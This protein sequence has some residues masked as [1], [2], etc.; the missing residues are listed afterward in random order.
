MNILK[1]F[2]KN[3]SKKIR[4]HLLVILI[5]IIL[6]SVI[7]YLY[8]S[9]RDF[10]IAILVFILTIFLT[11]ITKDSINGLNKKYYINSAMIDE[12]KTNL[13]ILIY[14]KYLLMS[15]FKFNDIKTI[16]DLDKSDYSDYSKNQS[17]LLHLRTNVYDKLK[18]EEF[19]KLDLE[20]LSSLDNYYLKI[21]EINNYIDVRK[22]HNATNDKI[23]EKQEFILYTFVNDLIDTY[24]KYVQNM[25]G[26]MIFFK[27]PVNVEE[28]REKLKNN[29]FQLRKEEYEKI[30]S[31]YK[32]DWYFILNKNYKSR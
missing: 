30:K 15:F 16:F 24:Y 31:D 18:T 14:N 17:N 27:N 4:I 13:H 29:G 9:S 6:S 19:D 2:Y 8:W 21:I 20:N 5:I 7:I 23:D 22:I 3:V 28:I 32:K 25:N 10:L 1:N 11:T 26:L 12:M